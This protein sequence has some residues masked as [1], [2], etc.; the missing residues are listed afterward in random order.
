MKTCMTTRFAGVRLL[1]AMVLA[2][3]GY[4]LLQASAQAGRVRVPLTPVTVAAAIEK[5]GVH[6]T[7]EQIDM[8][9]SVTAD[10]DD[11][12]LLANSA[13]LLNDGRIRLRMSCREAKA[14]LP[15]FATLRMD[16]KAA[17]LPALDILISSFQANL[18]MKKAR[19]NLS[20]PGE[21]ATLLMAD[22]QM[23]IALPV[24]FLDSGE[25]GREVRVSSLD[26][27][28]VFQAIVIGDGVV[29]GQLP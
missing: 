20:R 23:Q 19:S 2:A 4:C 16:N 6:V 26:H 13:Q 11:P 15:F 1:S 10:Q 28:K 5:A 3:A 17:A 29:R 24:L 12:S 8:P 18:P 9:A 14:C 21:H 25:V 22:R 7:P 27:K